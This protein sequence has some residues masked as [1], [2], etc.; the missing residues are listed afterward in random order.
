M[1]DGNVVIRRLEPVHDPESFQR[2][3]E[4]LG[5]GLRRGLL[6]LART[7]PAEKEGE[8]KPG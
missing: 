6:K 5:I 1:T 4:I 7:Q 2:A 3:M 8:Q